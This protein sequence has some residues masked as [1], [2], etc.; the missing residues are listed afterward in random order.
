MNTCFSS[1]WF[2]IETSLSIWIL[3]EFCHD[4]FECKVLDTYWH[5]QALWVRVRE[6]FWSGC[7][8]LRDLHLCEDQRP[9][10]LKSLFV[11]GRRWCFPG[12][13]A[14]VQQPQQTVLDTPPHTVALSFS[15][16]LSASFR[17]SAFPPLSYSPSG[18]IPFFISCVCLG[19]H[20][21]DCCS[22]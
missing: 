18:L 19:M 4:E 17:F 7:V 2:W 16:V 12:I 14:N 8:L 6:S 3:F 10:S 22:Y 1:S 9:D 20:H 21:A 13:Y 11:K 15:L 5:Q